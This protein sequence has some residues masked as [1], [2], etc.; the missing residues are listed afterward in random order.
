MRSILLRGALALSVAL[1]LPATAAPVAPFSATYEVR[2]NGDVLGEATLRLA[3]DGTDWRFTSETRGT[4]GLAKIAGVRIDESSRFRYV[5]GRPE[6]L[7]YRYAQKT[8]FNSRERSAVVDAAA[9]RITLRNR[10]ERQE[11]PYVQGILD[12]QLLT[13]ALMQAVAGGRRGAQALQVA[14]RNAVEA[15]TWWI[16]EAEAVPMGAASEQGLRIERRREDASGR[17]TVLWLDRDDGHLP[18]RIEQREDDGETVE[19]R[20]LRRG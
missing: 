7:D 18:L 1:A 9:G 15:Q 8:S 17:T 14:G 19:M 16:G 10:D 2:R 20:L 6:T 12:R 5:D 3:R 4:Q 11:A 13:V